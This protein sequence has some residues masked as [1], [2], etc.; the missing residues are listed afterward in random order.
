MTHQQKVKILTLSSA[1]HCKVKCQ[2][3]SSAGLI[4]IWWHSV[5]AFSHVSYIPLTGSRYV[6]VKMP[7]KRKDQNEEIV[8]GLNTTTGQTQPK[9]MIPVPFMFLYPE[10]TINP[11]WILWAPKEKCSERQTHWIHLILWVTLGHVSC[12]PHALA[13]SWHNLVCLLQRA[14]PP[15]PYIGLLDWNNQMPIVQI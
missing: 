6:C 7:V 4:S 3:V 12:S 8:V 10:W 9:L 5:S 11:D 13:C 14:K 2:L 1:A 15:P